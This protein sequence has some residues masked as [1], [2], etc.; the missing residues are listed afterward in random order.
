M[1]NLYSNNPIKAEFKAYLQKEFS[2]LKE[3]SNKEF[4]LNIVQIG[5]NLASS[6]YVG[7]K[8]KILAAN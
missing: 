3:T 4:V 6:K 5:D 1:P 7:I 2:K 8:K